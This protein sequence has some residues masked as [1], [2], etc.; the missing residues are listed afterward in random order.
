M[1]LGVFRVKCVFRVVCILKTYH[2]S[3]PEAGL[4]GRAQ[5]DVGG[6]DVWGRLQGLDLPGGLAGGAG[7]HYVHLPHAEPDSTEPCSLFICVSMTTMRF[8]L[9]GVHCLYVYL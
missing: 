3:Q 8:D 2:P 5:G 4:A 7:A 9:H 6:G 1:C